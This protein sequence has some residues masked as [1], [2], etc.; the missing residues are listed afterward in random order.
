M[1]NCNPGTKPET[2]RQ[3]EKHSN[4]L[5]SAKQGNNLSTVTKPDFQETLNEIDAEINYGITFVTEKHLSPHK[6]VANPNSI[7]QCEPKSSISPITYEAE[8]TKPNPPKIPNPTSP[9][10]TPTTKPMTDIKPPN[11]SLSQMP[12]GNKET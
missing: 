1:T 9:N 7:K 4:V 6:E 10:T 8:P 3:P 12:K 5:E 2:R 11:P